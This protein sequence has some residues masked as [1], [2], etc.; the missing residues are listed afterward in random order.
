MD[1]CKEWNHVVRGRVVNATNQST[2][3]PNPPS[4]PAMEGSEKPNV[5]A[6][7]KTARPQKSELKTT[8][9]PKLAAGKSKKRGSAN[10]KTEAA[11]HTTPNLVVPNQRSTSS[12]EVIFYLLRHLPLHA[13][14]ELT[15][16]LLTYISLPTG[17][18]HP[19]AVLNTV[20]FS[21]DEY[22]STP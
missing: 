5:T 4:Q 21:V 3:I 13:C 8:A 20:I 16:R 12:L 18:A 14:V 15:R 9:A 1:L 10:V 11:K 6:S 22:C 17:A 2:P 7:R 19:R